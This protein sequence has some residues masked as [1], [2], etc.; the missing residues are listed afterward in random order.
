MNV[1]KTNK[2]ST[3]IDLALLHLAIPPGATLPAKAIAAREN[4]AMVTNKTIASFFILNP[5]LP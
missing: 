4:E 1:L 3:L 5:P 2:I